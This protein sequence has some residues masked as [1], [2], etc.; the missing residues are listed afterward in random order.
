MHT[1]GHEAD[2]KSVLA[3][4]R[5]MLVAG[6]GSPGLV[7][8]RVAFDEHASCCCDELV[9]KFG[10]VGE[11]GCKDVGSAARSGDSFG[12]AA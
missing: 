3:G 6:A 12:H 10:V 9:G 11:L 1:D 4:D 7:V 5:E 2:A 8:P